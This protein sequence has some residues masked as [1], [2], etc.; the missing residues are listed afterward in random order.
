MA[1]FSLSDGTDEW[2][3]WVQFGRKQPIR[4]WRPAS[5]VGR[6]YW[7]G[8]SV[9]YVPVAHFRREGIQYRNEKTAAYPGEVSPIQLNQL[10]ARDAFSVTAERIRAFNASSSTF[11][12]SW[13]SMARLVLPSRLELKRPDGS[14]SAAPL[15]KVNLTTFL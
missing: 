8:T 10:R 15:A 1:G 4:S 5:N 11:S 9:H 13:K 3:E 14:S 2:Q 6:S 7:Q 12:P